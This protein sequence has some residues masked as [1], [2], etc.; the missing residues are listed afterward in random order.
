M[1]VWLQGG[2]NISGEYMD[3]MFV[4]LPLVTVKVV[5]QEGSTT[6]QFQP[7]LSSLRVQLKHI[8]L[9]IIKVAEQIPQL[10]CY[11][12][13]GKYYTV[14]AVLCHLKFYFFQSISNNN[15]PTPSWSGSV[16]SNWPVE[17]LKSLSVSWSVV[18]N[19]HQWRFGLTADLRI[20]GLLECTLSA[21]FVL[22]DNIQLLPPGSFAV[23]L[24]WYCSSKLAVKKAI[25]SAAVPLF[26]KGNYSNNYKK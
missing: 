9:V 2:N 4:Q 14:N 16:H 24:Q 15:R 7:E 20:D 17:Q 5:P 25:V 26:L 10:E 21:L 1:D 22:V 11:L 13:P 8:L 3:L 19:L 23:G 6:L 18:L 12:F